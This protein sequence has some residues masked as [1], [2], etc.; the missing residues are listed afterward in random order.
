MQHI[1]DVSN[2]SNG[3]KIKMRNMN[4]NIN[5]KSN[6]NSF[7][8]KYFSEDN[9]SLEEGQKLIHSY[10]KSNSERKT[11]ELYVIKK[12]KINI[13]SYDKINKNKIRPKSSISPNL[14]KNKKNRFY[15]PKNN[16][17][18]I[19]NKMLSSKSRKS[20]KNSENK[21]FDNIESYF[22]KDPKYQSLYIMNKNLLKLE[23]SN[24]IL[25]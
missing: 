2:I 5:Y 4:A 23:K 21:N 6:S 15:S 3:N 19:K 22:Y 13:G 7:Y 16:I 24:L 17:S 9:R 10:N 12:S 14:I 20:S 18:K 1:N 8:S 11:T 25:I